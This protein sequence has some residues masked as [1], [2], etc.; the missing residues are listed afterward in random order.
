MVGKPET[1]TP[2]M[3]NVSTTVMWSPIL[4]TRD[5]GSRYGIHTFYQRHHVGDF[6]R[7]ELMGGVEHADGTRE[8]WAACVPSFDVSDG[9]RR[10]RGA[11][12]DFTMTDGSSRPITVTALGDTGFHLGGGLYFGLD[13][14]WHGEDRGALHVD[15]EHIADC[16]TV[17]AAHRLHQI[18]D[19]LVR[20][21][22]PVGRGVGVGN[23]QTII[24]GP[25]AEWGLTEEASF[26]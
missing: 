19:N 22:D 16:T 23:M 14:H 17:E 1:E 18:R 13:G 5:D 25:H 10:V 26:M 9:N 6:D 4:M 21:E 20:V 2:H 15:G 11:T 12:L 7:S 3:A 24:S 8:A